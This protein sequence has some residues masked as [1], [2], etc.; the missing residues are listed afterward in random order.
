MVWHRRSGKDVTA[1]N[2]TIKKAHERIGIYYYLLP[3]Y[4]QAK[5]IIWDGITKDGQKFI[6]YIPKELVESKHETELK[7]K[8]KC[9]SIIQLV[10]TDNYDSIMGTN[11][12]GCVF[13]EYSLQNPK[14]WDF[15]RPILAENG[16]WAIFIYTPRG[17]NHGWDMSEMART[18]DDWYY[19]K[20][21]VRDT[22]AISDDAVEEERRAG[23]PEEIVLQ[24]FY[25]SF[26]AGLHGSYY[27]KQ[28]RKAEDEGRITNV[29][30]EANLPVDTWWD[31]GMGDSTAIWFTQN[32]G[33]EIH[34]I[35]YEEAEG[36][37]LAFYANMLK[38][39]PYTYGVHHM[40]HDAD[41]RELGTGKSRREIAESLGLRPIRIVEK[42]PIDDGINA[43]RI[44][45]N[46]FWFDEVNC[47]QGINALKNY[48]KEWDEKRQMFKAR[49]FHN[50]ASHAAD[51]MRYMAVGWKPRVK[52]RVYRHGF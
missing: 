40:P 49:P 47:R 6:E 48:Q 42:L 51:A 18:N 17:K 27:T 26:D 15:I 28:M 5:K 36:E 14:A 30:H 23:M 41:V 22:G 21:T 10:G 38:E 19:S 7:I 35:D 33:N 3:T 29:A 20:L 2:L 25:C 24:E 43:V 52:A 50:W 37:G 4:S 32:I 12:V 46:R 16:G 11:P 8:L 31:L 45:F 39:K 34:F 44:L 13:S 1:W 9:G